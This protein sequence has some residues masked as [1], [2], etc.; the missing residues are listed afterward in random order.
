MLERK[1]IDIRTFL[2]ET[3]I[4]I[5]YI[6]G[7]KGIAKN[8]KFWVRKE[9]KD[10]TT[11]LY[12][13]DVLSKNIFEYRGRKRTDQIDEKEIFREYQRLFADKQWLNY[14]TKTEKFRTEKAANL[15]VP[16]LNFIEI[17]VEYL[18]KVIQKRYS[19]KL[20]D[21]NTWDTKESEEY[22]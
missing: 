22:S 2:V 20:E 15:K 4:S 19:I 3:N 18:E 9:F 8:V 12:V 1:M 14:V 6:L 11:T 5:T 7:E 21:I 16:H 17:D 13:I 10:D